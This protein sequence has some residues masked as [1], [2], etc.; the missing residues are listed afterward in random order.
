MPSKQIKETEY[1]T[2]SALGKSYNVGI[3][4][5]LSLKPDI[6]DKLPFTDRM[7]SANNWILNNY[8]E[9]SYFVYCALELR[10]KLQKAGGY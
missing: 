6:K 2:I 4:Y 7:L 5:K 10:K 1:V 8:A 3:P 9:V